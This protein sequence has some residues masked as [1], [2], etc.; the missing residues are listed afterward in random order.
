MERIYDEGHAERILGEVVENFPRPPGFTKVEV[1]AVSGLLPTEH[2]PRTNALFIEGTEPTEYCSVHRVERVNRNTGKL[3]TVCTPPELVEDRVYEIYPPEAADWVRE[4]GI[5]QPPTQRDEIYGCSPE[6]GEVVILDPALGGHV[7]E[8]VPVRGNARSGEFNFY[9]LEFGEGL[10]P[11]AWS[12]IGGD[13]YNQVDNNVLEFWDVR[14]LQDGLYTLQLS[15]VE[16]SGNVKRSS[17]YVTVDNQPPEALVSYPWP[18]RVLQLEADEWANLTADV[19]DNVQIDRVEFYLDDELLDFSVVEPYAVKWVLGMQ[20]QLPDPDMEPI[21]GT[22]TITN[23]DG[24]W[25][26]EVVTVTWVEV[27]T[28][29]NAITQTWENGMMVIASG[30]TITESHV[31]HV[32]AIDAAGNQ[33]ESEKVRFYIIHKPEEK[34]EEEAGETG[35]IWWQDENL[36]AMMGSPAIVLSGR[37]FIPPSPRARSSAGAWSVRTGKRPGCS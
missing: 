15:V 32:V 33:T 2:C 36:L 20:D 28:T 12:Q 25:F 24:S 6:G 9:R 37:S 7:K 11:S 8:V 34:E 3:A 27:S 5:P 17:I 30:E 29:T 19:S 22:R 4:Q 10:N 26:T 21:T 14:G 31:V 16:H 18:G 13:H 1:C 35:A 23:P